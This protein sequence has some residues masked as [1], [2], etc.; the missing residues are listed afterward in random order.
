MNFKLSDGS[1][2]NT[3]GD[4]RKPAVTFNFWYFLNVENAQK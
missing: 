1:D 2:P 3:S 4:E